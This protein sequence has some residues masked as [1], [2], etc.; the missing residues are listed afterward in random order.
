MIE[1]QVLFLVSIFKLIQNISIVDSSQPRKSKLSIQLEEMK[2]RK[3]IMEEIDENDYLSDSEEENENSLYERN[4]RINYYNKNIIKKFN[5]YF[6]FD[7]SKDKKYEFNLTTGEFKADEF[8]VYNLIKYIV[9]KI[10]DS[11]IIIKDNNN[12]YSVSL[13]DIDEDN[14]D[15]YINNYEIKPFEFWKKKESENYSSKDLLRTINEEKISFF[16]KNPLNVFLMKQF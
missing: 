14:M 13:K 15:F 9:K 6:Y 8:H 3:E 11:N 12:H 10:N 16:S 7:L 2:F 1:F 4:E 5:V